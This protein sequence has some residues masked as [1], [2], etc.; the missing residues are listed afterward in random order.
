MAYDQNSNYSAPQRPYYT[1]RAPNSTP[2]DHRG[3]EQNGHSQENGQYG[4]NATSPYEKYNATSP[5][6]EKYNASPMNSQAYGGQ[7]EQP[8]MSPPQ[9]YPHR[10]QQP[11]APPTQ[12]QPQLHQRYGDVPAPG[13]QQTPQVTR[14]QAPMSAPSY[15][16]NVR[17]EQN[18][19]RKTG[20]TWDEPPTTTRRV[21]PVQQS[22]SY[23]TSP[24]HDTPVPAAATTREVPPDKQSSRPEK[25]HKERTQPGTFSI[26]PLMISRY[27]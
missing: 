6:D 13:F 14:A 27:N 17:H 21:D 10:P 5:Y 11:R 24:K 19:P 12:S 22:Q 4:Y 25:K 2:Y 16:D 7:Y 9:T 1:Q 26:P 8:Y 23:H 18:W 20:P 3:Y 15:Q